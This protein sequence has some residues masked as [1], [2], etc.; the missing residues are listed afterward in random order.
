MCI[1]LAVLMVGSVLIGL[2]Q[3]LATG[4]GASAVFVPEIASIVVPVSFFFVNF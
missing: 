3:A 1:I 4:F 2:F